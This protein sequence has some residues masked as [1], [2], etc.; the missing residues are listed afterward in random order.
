[1]KTKVL[2]VVCLFSFLGIT[3]DAQVNARLFRYPDVSKTDITFS[4]AGD[5]WIVSK[6]GG[7]ANK[8][9]DHTGIKDVSADKF[10]INKDSRRAVFSKS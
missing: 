9:K 10:W 2:T 8:I 3:L 4:Y 1:M 7:T 5:I 6:S